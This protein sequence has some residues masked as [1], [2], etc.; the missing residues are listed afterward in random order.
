M[1]LIPPASGRALVRAI[2]VI[3][4]SA[5][6]V[7][8]TQGAPRESGSRTTVGKLVVS[9][10]GVG[11]FRYDA[12]IATLRA[13]W[14]TSRETTMPSELV[15]YAAVELSRPGARVIVQQGDTVLHAN[16][17]GDLWFLSGDSIELPKNLRPASR[18][19]EIRRAYGI[20]WG[21]NGGVGFGDDINYSTFTFCSVP[22]LF[23]TV[24]T[25]GADSVGD[26]NDP[27]ASIPDTAH[28]L[29][30]GVD[31]EKTHFVP[32]DS[33]TSWPRRS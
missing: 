13:S 23:F 7:K 15:S 10:S 31:R 27:S 22:Y 30:V 19:G 21:S 9:D 20:G 17:P 32:C 24:S 5:C 14:P 4:L 16:A 33:S 25:V 1:C 29:N 12:S 2:V 18:W 26:P 11:P 28:A 8:Q 3:A 6:A